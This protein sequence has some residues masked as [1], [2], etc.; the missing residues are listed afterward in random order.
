[1]FSSIESEP[2]MV[3]KFEIKKH[4]ILNIIETFALNLYLEC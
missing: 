3:I 4:I 1:M 2:F